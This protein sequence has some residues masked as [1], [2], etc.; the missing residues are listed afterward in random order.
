[1]SIQ[2]YLP[3]FPIR[4]VTATSLFDGHDVAIT[5]MRRILQASGAEVIHLGHSR[6]VA[7]IVQCAI[8]EDVQAIA[9]TSYQG[10]H[11]HYF[12]YVYDLLQ[13]QGA[14]HIR[15]FGGGG[16]TILPS[17]I[18]ELHAYGICQIYSPDDGRAMGLQGMI[19]DVLQKSDFPTIQAVPVEAMAALPRKNARLVGSLISLAENC[20]DQLKPLHQVLA[21]LLAQANVPVVG[22]TGPGGAGKSSLIDELVRRFLQE[23]PEKHVAILS[24]D[25]TRKKSGGALLGDRI[26]MNTLRQPRVYMRSMATRDS[27]QAISQHVQTAI[28][29]CKA[30]AY[31]LIIVETSGTGQADSSVTAFSDVSLY[32]M[33]AEY[34][35]PSQLEKIDMLDFADLVAIN[36]FDKGFSLDALRDVRKQ[37]LRNHSLTPLSEENVP[38]YG[39]NAAIYN[40][41]GVNKLYEQWISCIQRKTGGLAS[42]GV[43]VGWQIS[44]PVSIIPPEKQNYLAD[45]VHM[46]HEYDRFVADQSAV[47]RQLAVSGKAGRADVSLPQ[48]KTEPCHET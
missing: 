6:S 43:S 11:L 40:D 37:Y 25:P 17:E 36:K 5:I 41:E 29:I 7:E 23:F 39:T 3:T 14:G 13:Q 18:D 24:I 38:V 22:V 1:M 26:R 30:A 35:A 48:G 20:P 27:G 42:G 4:I 12:K 19:N 33:T 44:P 34:G 2:S 47:A 46:L 31:D 15:I 45:I 32:V 21:P 16:G 28:H 8:Q 9:L 10:G